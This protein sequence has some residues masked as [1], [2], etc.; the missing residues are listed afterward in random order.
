MRRLV[1]Y[2][3][4]RVFSYWMSESE[5]IRLNGRW[6]PWMWAFNSEMVCECD[7]LVSYESDVYTWA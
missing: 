5:V 1:I 4:E 6:G 7:F 3:L 2:V